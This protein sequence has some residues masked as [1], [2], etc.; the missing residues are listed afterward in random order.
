MK[1]LILLLPI[2]LLAQTTVPP[3]QMRMGGLVSNPGTFGRIP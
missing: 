1:L 2:S 3:S